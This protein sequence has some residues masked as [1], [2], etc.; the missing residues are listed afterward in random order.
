MTPIHCYIRLG[1]AYHL[2][3]MFY[4]PIQ[5]KNAI[6]RIF[7]RMTKFNIG[8]YEKTKR[9]VIVNNYFLAIP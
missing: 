7:Q 5:S 2:D 9:K 8:K 3:L 4:N 1:V 6:Q